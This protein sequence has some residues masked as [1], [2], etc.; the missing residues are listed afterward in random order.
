[1]GPFG[2]FSP[3]IFQSK[4]HNQRLFQLKRNENINTVNSDL[5]RTQIRSSRKGCVK[6]SD[7]LKLKAILTLWA[8]QDSSSDLQ[9]KLHDV[10]KRIFCF[11]KKAVT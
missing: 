1:M 2:M 5:D 6:T 9:H 7:F 11:K 4:G 10:W 8:N 3:S